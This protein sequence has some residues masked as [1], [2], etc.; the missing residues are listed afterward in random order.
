V[1]VFSIESLWNVTKY[2]RDVKKMRMKERERARGAKEMLAVELA[3][4][5]KEGVLLD[6]NPPPTPQ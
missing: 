6:P 4:K 2:S 1:L 3:L 5:S